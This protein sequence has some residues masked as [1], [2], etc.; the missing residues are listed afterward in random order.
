MFEILYA[1]DVSEEI[2]RLP[3]RDRALIVGRIKEQ[4]RYEPTKPTRVKKLISGLR[5]PWVVGRPIWQ[6]R[7]GQHRVFYDVDGN[8]QQVTVRAI[9]R[10]PPHRTTEQIL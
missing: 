7:V 8:L 3:A 10:K 9:R 5:A 4:L 2:Q 6:L 1:D